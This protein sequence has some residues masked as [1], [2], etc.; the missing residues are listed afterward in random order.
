MPPKKTGKEFQWSDDEAEL[1][2]TVTHEYKVAKV[3]EGVDWESVKSKYSD[4]LQLMQEELPATQEAARNLTKDYPHTKDQITKQILT[5]KLKAI[6][7]KFRQ[8]IDSGRK[9]GHGRVVLLY[10]E[11]CQSVWGGSPATEQIE[12]GVESVDIGSSTTEAGG[13]H[14]IGTYPGGH[15]AKGW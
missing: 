11:L 14:I 13:R 15:G 10:F 4:I 7:L 5:T 1:L 9:S 12:G 6:R 2:L 8:A 3:A